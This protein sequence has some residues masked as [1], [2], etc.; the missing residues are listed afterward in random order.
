MKSSSDPFLATTFFFLSFL[1][2][3]NHGGLYPNHLIIMQANLRLI[4][5]LESLQSISLLTLE[6]E[7]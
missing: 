3:L 7:F 6:K 4:I 5:K 2:K 1:L